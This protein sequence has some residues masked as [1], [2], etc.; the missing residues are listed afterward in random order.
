MSSLLESQSI[1]P[2]VADTEP[3]QHVPLPLRWISSL[4][5]KVLGWE[6]IGSSRGA[7]K[8]V[9][10]T[11][12]TSA[13]DVILGLA[14]GYAS[15]VRPRWLVKKEAITGIVGRMILLAGGIPV[16]RSQQSNVV[17]QMADLFAEQDHCVLYVAP[18][19]TRGKAGYWRTGF[20]YIALAA[21]VPIVCAYLDYKEKKV[22]FTEQLYVSGDL[23]A[24]MEIIHTWFANMTPKYPDQVGKIHLESET[25]P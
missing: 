23:E 11:R 7:P 12:H 4:L 14:G 15:G 24:D 1:E 2:S 5:L 19:G 18:E 8:F 13:W 21:N 22:G 6:L 20:Y 17:D 3:H 16:D 10:A 9:V 25:P